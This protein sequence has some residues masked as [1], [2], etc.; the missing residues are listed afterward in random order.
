MPWS[1]VIQKRRLKWFGH[2][3]RLPDDTPANRA[4]QYAVSQYRK[5]RGRSPSTWISVLKKL[6]ED[7]GLSWNEARALASDLEVWKKYT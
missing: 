7:H 2:V 3:I 1:K 5:P 4:I 6:I